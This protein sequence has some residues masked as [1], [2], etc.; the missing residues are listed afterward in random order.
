MIRM[1]YPAYFLYNDNSW[2]EAEDSLDDFAQSGAKFSYIGNP[3]VI[4]F[5]D[6]APKTRDRVEPDDVLFEETGRSCY[7]DEERAE[8]T[9]GEMMARA[10][11][12]LGKSL[13]RFYR[14][15]V[16]P[17]K[18]SM[19][20]DLTLALQEEIFELDL[21]DWAWERPRF[22]K[23]FSSYVTVDVEDY[24]PQKEWPFI[25]RYITI[26]WE[27]YDWCCDSGRNLSEFVNKTLERE[28]AE[29]QVP[30]YLRG[31]TRFEED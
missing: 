31:L 25:E 20:S 7:L 1:T 15:G 10:Q 11:R 16:N 4:I 28:I 22:G 17:P 29:K 19:L 8:N 23:T 13:A 6:L 27:L 14:S 9:P 5:P 3:P 21:L 12:T 30:E 2:P 26:P 24:L 18:A